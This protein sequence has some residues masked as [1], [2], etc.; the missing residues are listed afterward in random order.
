M[1]DRVD[2]R[3]LLRCVQILLG[4]VVIV[5]TPGDG[6]AQSATPDNGAAQETAA[7]RTRLVAAE[8][9]YL[10][11]TDS[12]HVRL[13]LLAAARTPR[14]SVRGGELTIQSATPLGSITRRT[15]QRA[16]EKSW[17]IVRAA[18]GDSAGAA[19]TVF[20]LVYREDSGGTFMDPA[21]GHI[22]LPRAPGRGNALT[23]PLSESAATIEIV[24][25]VGTLASLRNP[26]P[27]RE[28]I[29]DWM[30]ARPYERPDW[31]AIAVML[32]TMNAAVTRG[33]HA[34]SVP[35]CE[36][37]L[38]LT[39]VKDPFTEW[40]APEDWFVLARA[41]YVDR[42]RDW[43]DTRDDCIVRHRADNL[44]FARG[45]RQHY[46]E[47]DHSSEKFGLRDYATPP[48]AR[49]GRFAASLACRAGRDSLCLTLTRGMPERAELAVAFGMPA[50]GVDL[51]G[52]STESFWWWLSTSAHTLQAMANELGPARFARIWQSSRPLAD[53]YYAETSEQL[54]QWSRRREERLDG[55]YVPGPWTPPL[56]AGLSLLFIAALAGLT[57]RYVPKARLV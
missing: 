4:I 10:A 57:I 14:D 55:L 1:S 19:T 16:A 26:A 8:R 34:G 22:W 13:T 38:A 41:H 21:R 18:L 48:F 56:S 15:L 50:I 53:A 11:A 17:S 54:A 51:G 32:A 40:Y 42:S 49:G 27:L 35:Q 6:A 37:A 7:L 47:S 2:G 12:H 23:L 30:P 44:E 31:E 9:A 33:C 43:D 24:D 20:R 3:A 36:S 46:T 5:A 28:W 39:L 29:G 52:T 25:L 45:Y